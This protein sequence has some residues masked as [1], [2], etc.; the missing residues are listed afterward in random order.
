MTNNGGDKWLELFKETLKDLNISYND[1]CCNDTFT[2]DNFA[3][4]IISHSHV[5]CGY[6]DTIGNVYDIVADDS[7]IYVKTNQGWAFAPLTLMGP[8][9]R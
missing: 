7:N 3:V 6:S 8:C 9:E 5:P 4:N 1:T 2:P